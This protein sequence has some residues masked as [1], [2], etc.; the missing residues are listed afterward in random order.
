[1]TDIGGKADSET[2]ASAQVFDSPWIWHEV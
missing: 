2:C 1:V